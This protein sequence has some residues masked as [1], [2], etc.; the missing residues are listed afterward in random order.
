M[1]CS[2]EQFG[3]IMKDVQPMA[4]KIVDTVELQW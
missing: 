1:D 3:Q 2:D 4:E